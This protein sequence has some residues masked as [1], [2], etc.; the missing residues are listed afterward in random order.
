MNLL[1]PQGEVRFV[2]CD[3]RGENPVF[4]EVSLSPKSYQRLTIAP[5]VWLAFQGVSPETNLIMDLIDLPHDPAESIKKELDEI[6]YD[7]GD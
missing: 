2:L 5:G 7:W 1:V 4:W 3:D 6:P